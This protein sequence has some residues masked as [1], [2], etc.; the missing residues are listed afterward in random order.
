MSPLWQLGLTILGIFLVLLV[1][2]AFI[3]RNEE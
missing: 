1:I 2:V 3:G